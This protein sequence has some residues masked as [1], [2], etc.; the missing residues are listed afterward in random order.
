MDPPCRLVITFPS[1]FAPDGATSGEVSTGGGFPSTVEWRYAEEHGDSIS[2]ELRLS[3]NQLL[4]ESQDEP[5][6]REVELVLTM[7]V[8]NPSISPPDDLNIW[9]FETMSLDSSSL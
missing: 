8:S 9:R 1:E 7:T 6:R 2:S 3:D 4:I 5:L